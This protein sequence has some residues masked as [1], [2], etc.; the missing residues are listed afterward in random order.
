VRESSVEVDGSYVTDVELSKKLRP[1]NAPVS[2]TL[3]MRSKSTW[4]R[5]ATTALGRKRRAVDKTVMER[6]G[7]DRMRDGA[8][9]INLEHKTR[10]TR[11]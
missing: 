8:I 11:V 9:M 3:P 10:R 6:A 5:D 4:G 2:P 1:A 7:E